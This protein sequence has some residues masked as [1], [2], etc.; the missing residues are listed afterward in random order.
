MHRWPAQIRGRRS[1]CSVRYCNCLSPC[2]GPPRT[3]WQTC[4]HRTGGRDSSV[5][6]E[7]GYFGRVVKRT[8][9]PRV[10]LET[11]D[12]RKGPP[13]DT[14]SVPSG[15]V[16]GFRCPPSSAGPITERRTNATLMS[17]VREV[18]SQ[19]RPRRRKSR[20]KRC[21]VGWL[22]KFVGTCWC[23]PARPQIPS[24]HGAGP[25]SELREDQYCSSAKPWELTA[26]I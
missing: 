25:R 2:A 11:S 22:D 4:S 12:A 10:A 16:D 14:S 15:A 17:A 20:S 9:P 13:R 8:R 3:S 5:P 7:S 23:A 1:V 26:S 21:R 6:G 18:R 19:V 24:R